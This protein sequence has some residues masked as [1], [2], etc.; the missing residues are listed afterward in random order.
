MEIIGVQT[1]VNGRVQCASC[2]RWFPVAELDDLRDAPCPGCG[3]TGQALR[4]RAQAI[5]RA[6]ENRPPNGQP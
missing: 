5:E 1:G 4:Q 3:D 6:L 2:R